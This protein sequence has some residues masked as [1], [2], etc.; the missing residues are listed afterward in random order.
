MGFAGGT[1]RESSPK[2]T[3]PAGEPGWKTA[4]QF[5]GHDPKMPGA[6]V[7]LSSLKKTL[8]GGR[9]EPEGK[10][11]GFGMSHVGNESAAAVLSRDL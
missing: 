11:P 3:P 6:G 4:P 7:R 9:E 10:D 5:Q 2:Q 8:E 1:G